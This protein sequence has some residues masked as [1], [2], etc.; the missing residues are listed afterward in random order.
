M[1]ED[2]LWSLSQVEQVHATVE[3][4]EDSQYTLGNDIG[5][6]ITSVN[7]ISSSV[8]S[9][10]SEVD[11][12][13]TVVDGLG[14]GFRNVVKIQLSCLG[15]LCSIF[16]Q[17]SKKLFPSSPNYLKL[18]LN[19]TFADMLFSY[20]IQTTNGF[21]GDEQD[22]ISDTGATIIQ[23]FK[24]ESLSV[25]NFAKYLVGIALHSGHTNWLLQFL[26]YSL[27]G[28]KPTDEFLRII[29]QQED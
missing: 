15:V 5:Y 1:A 7:S 8:N 28:K 6:V 16:S 17:F 14:V 3:R 4:I 29:G 12:I 26:S 22:S 10:S 21:L 27:V 19:F 24:Y 11:K 9:I 13:D 2:C 18:T 20:N 25:K 23:Y